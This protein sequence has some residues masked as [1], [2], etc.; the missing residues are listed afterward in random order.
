MKRFVVI[1]VDDETTHLS[2]TESNVLAGGQWATRIIPVPQDDQ[3]ARDLDVLT[4]MWNDQVSK[5]MEPALH[6]L[7]RR[8]R[9]AFQLDDED[10]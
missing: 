3:L 9:A 7:A 4:R 8:L 2:V 10:A 1:P 5:Y 6:A